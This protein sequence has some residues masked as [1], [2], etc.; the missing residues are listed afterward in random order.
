MNAGGHGIFDFIHRDPKTLQPYFSASRVEPPKHGI[1]LGN[2]VIPIG[3]GT[4][5]QLRQGK[6]FWETLDD[7]ERAQHGHPHAF[8]FPSGQSQG[9]HLVR[10]GHAGFAWQ[11]RNIFLLHRRP[12]DRCGRGGRRTDYSR[13]GGRFTGESKVDRTRQH[14]S[15]RIAAHTRTLHRFRRSSG[16]C[17]KILGAG[18]DIRTARRGMER[19]GPHSVPTD[20]IHRQR[21]RN[22]PLLSEAGASALR[23]VRLAHQH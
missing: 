15:Q 4:A 20:S 12:H 23:A 7:Y 18:P 17:G 14:V 19:L 11:L 22:L 2:W 21:E 13:P 6:A 5:E 10:H 8:E 1:H 9:I 3:G 16:G